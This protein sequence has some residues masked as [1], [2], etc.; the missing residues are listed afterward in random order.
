MNLE[1]MNKL[2][3]WKVNKQEKIIPQLPTHDTIYS[4]IIMSVCILEAL[5][6]LLSIL[7]VSHILKF[8]LCYSYNNN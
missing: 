5:Q 8:F 6:P 4:R 1:C 2:E 7:Y 3:H